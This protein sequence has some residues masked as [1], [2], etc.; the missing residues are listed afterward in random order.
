MKKI[1]EIVNK[2]ENIFIVLLIILSTIGV[3]FCIALGDNDEL[4]NFQNV[5]KMYN[6]FQI[7]KDANVICTPL[8]FYFGNLI[9]NILGANFF[10][11]RVYN[12]LILILYYFL[13]YKILR[14]LGISINISTTIILILIMIADYSIP[15]VMANYN[16]L[17]LVFVLL[18]VYLF[19]KNKCIINSKNIIIQSIICFLVILT[20]QNIG[21]YYSIALTVMI[22]CKKENNKILGILQEAGVVLILSITFLLYLNTNNLLEGFINYTFLG[23]KQ[24]ATNN[25]SISLYNIVI[26]ILITIINLCTSIFLVKQTKVSIGKEEKDN[27][28]MLNCFS[29]PISLLIYP[30]INL[31]H[32]LFAITISIVLFVYIVSIILKKCNIKLKKINSCM[33][34]IL[35]VLI[36]INIAIN[37][38]KFIKWTKIVFGDEY[39]YNY[40][41]PYFGAI[42][43]EDM[44]KNIETIINYIKIKEKEGKN[45][46]IFSP[47]AALYMVPLKQSNGYYDLP[48]NGNV[49]GL[50][51]EDII[52]NLK[53][54]TNS[55]ILIEKDEN[56]IKWQENKHI[57]QVIKKNFNYIEDI[58][59]F[60]VY[61][62]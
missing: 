32:F 55:L 30:I 10:I 18:G 14:K 8:F 57:L 28:F 31:T 9:F 19:I 26:Y 59:E 51:E 60:S 56:N 15:R 5:Y 44:Y 23:M 41:E 39:Y 2:N 46:I 50:G 20:K 6:G 49:G 58:E 48:F 13:I 17:A 3:V 21:I 33:T 62:P 54:E 1:L 12:I 34:L 16:L 37:S 29:I 40:S 38:Y 43:D 25:I 52:N 4:W 45:V 35:L 47:K 27:L 11:F 42:V 24:F 53:Q 7:Y 36:L 22:L 61:K